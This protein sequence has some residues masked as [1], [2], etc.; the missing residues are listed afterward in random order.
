MA[1]VTK[2]MIVSLKLFF[3]RTAV[4]VD[5]AAFNEDFQVFRSFNC[6]LHLLEK[7]GKP[8]NFV[9]FFNFVVCRYVNQTGKNVVVN[10]C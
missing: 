1:N 8:E 9:E 3:F 10:P 7:N 2:S 4:A 6:H 5:F